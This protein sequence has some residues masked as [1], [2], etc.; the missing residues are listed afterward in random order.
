MQPGFTVEFNTRNDILAGDVITFA[1]AYQRVDKSA[2]PD[3][4]N[5]ARSPGAA[6]AIQR[7]DDAGGQTVGLDLIVAGHFL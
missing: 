3:A 6:F 4:G 1:T 2:Q 7:H 5:D